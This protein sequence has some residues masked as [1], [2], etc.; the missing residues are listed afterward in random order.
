VPKG[1]SMLRAFSRDSRV[2]FGLLI[3]L[4]FS[5]VVVGQTTSAQSSAQTLSGQM[6]TASSGADQGSSGQSSL[7]QSLADAARAIQEKK[8]TDG[9]TTPPKVFTNADLPKNPEGYTGPP[10]DEERPAQNS[11]NTAREAAQERAAERAGA[12]WRQQ[13]VAQRNRI[14]MLQTRI[15][16]LRAQIRVVDPN[17]A[18][19]Y[20]SG[21]S[22]NGAQ[23]T[24]IRIL[25]DMEANLSQQRQRLE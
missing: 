9:S 22:Y 6:T 5:I 25:K 20:S 4:T 1:T 8:A 21:T 13:I 23:A 24:Q 17:A 18:D 19:D 7:G 11:G 12:Q 2:C 14:A 3:L 10:A 15:D 16:R